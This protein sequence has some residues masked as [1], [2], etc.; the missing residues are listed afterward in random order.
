MEMRWWST[1]SGRVH[2]HASRVLHFIYVPNAQGAERNLLFE[3]GNYKILV[4]HTDG[5]L[6]VGTCIMQ[7]CHVI[8]HPGISVT[9][10]QLYPIFRVR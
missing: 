8:C 9:A 5:L 4:G 3:W 2:G 10:I 1:T 6:E 7:V